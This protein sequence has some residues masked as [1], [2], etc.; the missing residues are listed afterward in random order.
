MRTNRDESQAREHDRVRQEMLD[1]TIADS[2]PTSDPPSSIPDPVIAHA[3]QESQSTFD[4]LLA[5]LPPRSWAAISEQ[6][7]RVVGTGATREEA[8]QSAAGYQ[9]S[10]LKVVRVGQDPEAPEQAA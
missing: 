3:A 7:R 1:K 5:N 10:Q 9:Q 6:E 4:D 8:V 2:F